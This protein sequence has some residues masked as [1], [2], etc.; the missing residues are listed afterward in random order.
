MTKQQIIQQLKHRAAQGDVRASQALQRLNQKQA[1]NP[2]AIVG[3]VRDAIGGAIGGAAS[4]GSSAASGVRGLLPGGSSNGN[5]MSDQE[6]ADKARGHVADV[7]ADIEQRADGGNGNDYADKRDVESLKDDVSR[8]RSSVA[9]M[10][11]SMNEIADKLHV[12]GGSPVGAPDRYDYS[13]GSIARSK[14]AGKGGF[15]ISD[16]AQILEEGEPL[17]RGETFAITWPSEEMSVITGQHLCYFSVLGI[18]DPELATYFDIGFR[19]NDR[20]PFAGST[21]IPVHLAASTTFEPK[22]NFRFADAAGGGQPKLA[23]DST[24]TAT[25]TAT[26]DLEEAP[27]DVFA[28]VAI[29][30]GGE[31]R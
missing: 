6:Y 7:A 16:S 22:T 24:L 1:A 15:V 11:S 12:G 13:G 29:Q 20:D 21:R 8:L 3:G 30:G 10:R 28:S 17:E 26:R 18:N 19:V 25:L 9:S 14:D 4:A 2:L 23:L 27:Q 31:C 5:G